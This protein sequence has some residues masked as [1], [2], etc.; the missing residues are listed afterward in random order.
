MSSIIYI[1]TV[2]Y[3]SYVIYAVLGDEIAARIKV[4]APSLVSALSK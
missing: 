4:T 1:A 3:F 2:F